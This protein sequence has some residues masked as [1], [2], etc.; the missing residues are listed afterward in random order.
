MRIRST[1]LVILVAVLSPV[2]CPARPVPSAPST[3]PVGQGVSSWKVDRLPSHLPVPGTDV[4]RVRVPAVLRESSVLDDGAFRPTPSPSTDGS[5]VEQVIVTAAALEASFQVLADRET[6]RGVPTVV[7]TVEWI[8]TSYHG[9]DDPARIRTFLREAYDFWG[10]RSVVLGGDQELV[11]TRYVIW[12][13]VE[14]PADMYYACLDGE[15]NEDGDAVFAEPVT[16]ATFDGFVN[17]VAVAPDGRTWVGTY[18]GVAV[19]DGGTF[20]SWDGSD[21]LPGDAIYAVDVAPDGTVWTAGDQGV[22]RWDGT[23]WQSFAAAEGY[24]GTAG[25]AIEA[26]SFTEAWI[27]S[28]NG[29][30]H[31]AAG[32][33]ESWGTAEGLP[34]PT[35]SGL[36]L[37]GG[38][39]W[40]ATAGGAARLEGGVVTVYNTT[41]SGILSNW[42]IAVEVDDLGRVWFGHANNYFA[43]G[44]LSRFDGAGWVTDDL[45]AWSGKS[46]RSFSIEPGGD[47]FWAA[48]SGGLLHRTPGGDELL[49]A[50]D[51]LAA[52]DC[53]S[54][55]FT[56]GGIAVATA[57]G[58]S[59]GTPGSWTNFSTES[60]LPVAPGDYDD[61]DLMPELEL[62]RVP[63]ET[64]AEVDAYVQKL[65]DYQDGVLADH[66]ERTLLLGENMFDP[67]DGKEACQALKAI[68]PGS[69]THEELYE[70]DGTENVAAVAAGLDAGPAWVIDVGHGSYDAMGVGAGQEL[71]FNGDIRDTDGGGRAAMVVVYA[72]NSGAFDLESSSEAFLFHAAGGAIG[73]LANTREAMPTTDAILNE[74]VFTDLFA[75]SHGRIARSIRDVWATRAVTHTST[76][77]MQTWLRHAFLSRTFQGVPSLAVW[78]SAPKPLVVTHPVAAPMAR[79]PFTVHVTDSL[80]S[81][82]LEGALVCVSKADEDYAYGTTDAAGDVTF[83]FRPESTGDI[84][85]VVTA[86]DRFPYTGI[87]TVGNSTG[88]SPVADGWQPTPA[89]RG[90]AGSQVDLMLAVRNVGLASTGGWS[91]QLV[92]TDGDV[93]IVG[94]TGLLPP[95]ASGESAWAGPFTVLLDPAPLDGEQITVRLDG[96]GEVAFQETYAIAVDAAGLALDSLDVA[97][98]DLFPVVT[99]DGSV[100]T[101]PVTATLRSLDGLGAVVDSLGGVADVAPGATVPFSN[102]F[103]VTGDPEARFE[104]TIIDAAGRMLVKEIDRTAPEPVSGLTAEPRDGA[105]RLAWAPSASADVVGYVVETSPSAGVWVD[106]FDGP[107]TQGAL[108]EV[109]LAPGTS[110]DFRVRALDATGNRSAAVALTA[111]AAPALVPGWPR[112]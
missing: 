74:E 42:V 55:T 111:H 110:R 103:T 105:A 16:A 100:P 89:R 5:P 70:V 43:R 58:L 29:L 10:T 92:A 39:V 95:L 112:R 86:P 44:G 54:T 109:A 2:V 57:A 78:R 8:R 72:C 38:A 3:V 93:T 48:T 98:N 6:H 33:W 28:G 18:F 37:D 62:G 65:A 87:A 67:G 36:A 82:P 106:A 56:A 32:V 12:D 51:G 85:V 99:N 19:L 81:A 83:D 84:D 96:T 77:R 69:F 107:L 50:G 23:A 35:V 71:F 15:W 73:V 41:N 52:T 91:L 14:I 22:A 80:T 45:P 108:A 7:R 79:A 60:G 9:A 61:I 49:D 75:S 59:T 88:P 31:F 53:Y 1:L 40:M 66:A 76:L 21:G 4:S 90:G 34:N 17:D 25:L 47:E 101:G 104:L 102:G 11:P 64:P 20:Q 30:A 68:F 94:G 46:V 63:A 97:G 24:P 26:L 13:D 27:G